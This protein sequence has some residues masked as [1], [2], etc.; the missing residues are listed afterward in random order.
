MD[1]DLVRHRIERRTRE[2]FERGVEAEVAA[3]LDGELSHTAARIHGLQD[4]ASLLA[5]QIDRDEATRRLDVRTRQ[6]A[7]RQRV[8]MRRL[9][10]LR[11]VTSAAEL[12][13]QEA[14]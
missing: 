6:Y 8:W 10:G 13:A 4:V 14:A 2:M 12:L 7:R 9:P 5:G 11:P 3:A 1:A